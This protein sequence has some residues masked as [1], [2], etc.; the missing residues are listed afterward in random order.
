MSISPA[1]RWVV[2]WPR[3]TKMPRP[4]YGSLPRLRRVFIVAYG[5]VIGTPIL[6]WACV[7]RDGRWAIGMSP[8]DAYDEWARNGGMSEPFPWS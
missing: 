5:G 3:P 2:E 6:G 4:K 8:E 7:S 1:I